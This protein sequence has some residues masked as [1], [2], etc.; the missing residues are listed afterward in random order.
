[1]Q[2]INAGKFI[3]KCGHCA[4]DAKTKC[5]QISVL[6]KDKLRPFWKTYT[7]GAL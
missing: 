1:M 5:E 4:G 2:K 7:L 6:T 3:T